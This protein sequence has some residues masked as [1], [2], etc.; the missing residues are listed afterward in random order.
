VYHDADSG[1]YKPIPIEWECRIPAVA[2]LIAELD[3][4]L[5]EW[6]NL[7]EQVSAALLLAW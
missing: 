2:K 1:S 6:Q 5:P 7:H 4:A 3:Q